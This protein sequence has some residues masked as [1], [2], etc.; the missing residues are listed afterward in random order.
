MPKGIF[1]NPIERAEK[2]RLKRIGTK[3][4]PFSTEW[5]RKISE[6][7]KKSQA[8]RYKRTPEIIEK[9]RQAR[10]RQVFTPE[11]KQKVIDAIIKIN[12]ERVGIKHHNWKGGIT[13]EKNKIRSS[14]KYAKW[15]IKIFERDNY[16]CQEC[17]KKGTYLQAHHIKSFSDYPELRYDINNGKTLCL[18][19]HKKT[20]IYGHKTKRI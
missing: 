3:R 16:T 5:K 9:I 4:P 7:C 18:E 20:F 11:A 6:S 15:R 1:K 12:K 13:L 17:G 10:L 2:I 14:R 8:G 19:C